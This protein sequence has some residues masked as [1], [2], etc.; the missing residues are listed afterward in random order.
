MFVFDIVSGDQFL[1]ISSL[2]SESS[3]LSAFC[4]PTGPATRSQ[5]GGE[6]HL[7]QK[8]SGKQQKG[9]EATEAIAR[10][11]MFSVQRKLVLNLG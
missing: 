1:M 11:A 6:R 7:A 10:T 8:L 9:Q 4:R 3:N 5:E 2:S